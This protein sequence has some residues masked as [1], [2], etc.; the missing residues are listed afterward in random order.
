MKTHD[1]ND[2]NTEDNVEHVPTDPLEAQDQ[3]LKSEKQ[4]TLAKENLPK[5]I[6]H[7]I[8]DF[9]KKYK[10]EEDEEKK[11][12]NTGNKIDNWPVNCRKC[13]QSLATPESF[14]QH[15]DDHWSE[16]MCC[17]VCGLLTR[18]PDGNSQIFRLYVFGPSGLKD[19]GSA[20]LRCKI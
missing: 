15:M 8:E 11:N 18:L 14:N 6:I 1:T 3:V 16:D 20:T 5:Y 13:S 10:L 19:Y 4:Q 9:G 17:P 12:A 2:L 7:S